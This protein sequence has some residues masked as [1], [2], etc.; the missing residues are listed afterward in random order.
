MI[1]FF[2]TLG[3]SGEKGSGL[4][5]SLVYDIIKK[6]GGD[7]AVR[8]EVGSGTEM[9]FTMP[10]SS[11]K[12]L[13]VDDIRTDRILYSKLLKYGIESQPESS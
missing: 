2:T 11:T 9:I 4:G 5:L 3:T 13:L 1:G 10:V 8:S 12:I 6:H 7:I